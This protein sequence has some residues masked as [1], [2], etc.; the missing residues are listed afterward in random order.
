MGDACRITTDEGPGIDEDIKKLKA[1]TLSVNQKDKN[2][3]MSNIRLVKSEQI[4]K[5]SSITV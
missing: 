3:K 5:E 2:N 4:K 1:I